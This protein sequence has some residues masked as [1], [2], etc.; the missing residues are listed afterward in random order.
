MSI[1]G[2]QTDPDAESSARQRT[3][4]IDGPGLFNKPAELKRIG[5]SQS[6]VWN[7]V[8]LNQTVDA[9]HAVR[10]DEGDA[11]NSTKA[12]IIGL[13]GVD[14]KDELEGMIAA[15][16]IAGHNAA[17]ECYRR[18]MLPNQVFEFRRE[19][20]NQASKLSR[21]FATLLEA[22][23]R[24][25]G[26]GHQKVVVEHVHVYKGGQA[27]VGNVGTPGGGFPS[28][29]EAKPHAKQ[30]EDASQ[31]PMRGSNAKQEPMPITGDAQRALSNARRTVPGRSKGKQE[32]V[33]ARPLHC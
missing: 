18:A 17:M 32:C 4:T 14:P 26:K 23:N 10:T 19:N 2:S 27:I 20:L 3:I 21:T 6:D 25:R 13:V 5:G 29:L 22:L 11:S 12:A 9:L 15:Q 30:I 28:E 16:L 31:P 1:D 33:Q 8:I 7:N 24:H